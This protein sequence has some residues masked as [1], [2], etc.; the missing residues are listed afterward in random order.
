METEE[1]I[2]NNIELETKIIDKDILEINSIASLISYSNEH[3]GIEGNSLEE[4]GIKEQ[5][6]KEA[7]VKFLIYRANTKLKFIGTGCRFGNG[8]ITDKIGK[9]IGIFKMAINKRNYAIK[10]EPTNKS[11]NKLVADTKLHSTKLKYMQNLDVVL[12]LANITPVIQ[13]EHVAKIKYVIFIRYLNTWAIAMEKVHGYTLC[14]ESYNK[15][16]G[17]STSKKLA[18]LRKVARGL[19][20]F[21]DNNIT[22]WDIKADN[23]MFDKRGKTYIIDYDNT[24]VYNGDKDHK[25]LIH[26]HRFLNVAY[27]LIVSHKPISSAMDLIKMK[28][29]DQLA[30]LL[31]NNRKE[32]INK[33]KVG[34]KYDKIIAFLQ[35]NKMSWDILLELLY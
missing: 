30:V 11:K 4:I 28:V 15:V 34:E 16:M 8:I 2:K 14:P 21:Y 20:Y 18:T 32:Y 25:N 6:L 9:S 27:N 12:N 35:K 23:I 10:I 22:F 29:P 26:I 19:K 17:N 1:N 24:H 5:M 31:F 3:L 33:P 7:G 13:C